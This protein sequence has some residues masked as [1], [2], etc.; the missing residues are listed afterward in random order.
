MPKA[1]ASQ[2][3]FR[4]DLKSLPEGFVVL[5]RLNYGEMIRR[6]ELGADI[7]MS[8]ENK[9]DFTFNQTAVALYEFKHSVID[10]NLE[11][12]ESHKLNFDNAADVV[13]LDPRVAQE[14][15]RRIDEL[16]KPEED[17]GPLPSTSGESSPQRDLPD[18]KTPEQ[19]VSST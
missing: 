2:E 3:G 7:S 11:D 17:L 14:I 15:E 9:A 5:R 18:P 1:V 6:R 12:E 4:Y 10:H 13:K 19:S 8:R 16:N